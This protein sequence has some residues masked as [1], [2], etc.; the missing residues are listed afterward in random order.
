[1]F[2]TKKKY[3]ELESKYKALELIRIPEKHEERIAE[4][5]VKIAKLWSMLTEISATGKEKLSKHGR[6]FG[7]PNR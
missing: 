6:R 5:E 4:L 7:N 2:V 3:D 1:M